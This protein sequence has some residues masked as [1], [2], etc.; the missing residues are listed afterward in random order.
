M[1]K[2][3]SPDAPIVTNEKGGQ[4]SKCEYG[5]RLIDTE[6]LLSLAEVLQYGAT[7]YAPD[8]WRK[9]PSGEHFDHM[10][11]HYYAHLTGDRSDDHLGHMFCR[12]MMLAATLRAEERD[13]GVDA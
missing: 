11:T 6:T 1:I 5:F 8:N 10:L 12:A 2:G 9:I 3:V 4:Q 7:K 13:K